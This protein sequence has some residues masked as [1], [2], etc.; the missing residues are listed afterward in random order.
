MFAIYNIQG[1]AFRDSLEALQ[2]V[3]KPDKVFEAE[4]KQNVSQDET[5][6][7]QGLGSSEPPTPANAKSIASYRQMLDANERTV[8]VHAYQLMTHP[9]LTIY[10]NKSLKEAFELFENSAVNQLPVVSPQLD[11]VGMLNRNDVI[12]AYYMKSQ[13]ILS[14]LMKPEVIT[15][16]PISDVRRVAKVLHEYQQSALPVVN[17]Q[18]HLVGIITKT[19]ILKALI[20]DPPISLWA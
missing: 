9:V 12:K 13:S 18:D 2:R 1:R 20:K 6:V 15:V 8:I 14:E 4:L 10:A 3:R 5:T 7:V 17:E 16:D 11:I 19:D